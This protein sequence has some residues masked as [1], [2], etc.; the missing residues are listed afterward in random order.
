MDFYGRSK[1]LNEDALDK[2]RQLLEET[3]GFALLE[4]EDEDNSESATVL[5]ETIATEA[6]EDGTSFSLTVY[7]KWVRT[8]SI[9]NEDEYKTFAGELSAALTGEDE[10]DKHAYLNAQIT[11]TASF[12]LTDYA[13][14]YTEEQPFAGTLDGGGNTVT[15]TYSGYTGDVSAFIGASTGSISDL[16]VNITVNAVNAEGNTVYI[17]AVVVA[18][19]TM[20][21]V[22]ASLTVRTGDGAVAATG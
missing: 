16:T 4:A 12:D 17:G 1:V 22:T 8:V 13:P 10:N 20:E 14:L 21:N 19:G 5:S 18:G 2:F 9:G 3:T 6:K 15:V 11:L 7:A